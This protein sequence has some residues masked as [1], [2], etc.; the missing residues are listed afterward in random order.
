MRGKK[1]TYSVQNPRSPRFSIYSDRV[2]AD[3]S[4][5]SSIQCRQQRV[6]F[7]R[8]SYMSTCSVACPVKATV[9][10]LTALKTSHELLEARASVI[11]HQILIYRMPNTNPRYRTIQE[12]AS[13]IYAVENLIEHGWITIANRLGE[14]GSHSPVGEIR[15]SVET[16]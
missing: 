8:G 7:L 5:Q 2:A 13:W 10:G 11:S 12:L 6:I 16:L 15:S 14:Y 1:R 9:Q 3:I 4:G